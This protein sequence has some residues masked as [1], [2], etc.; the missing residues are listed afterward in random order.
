M[1]PDMPGALDGLVG[2]KYRQDVIGAR[3]DQLALK[4]MWL[5]NAKL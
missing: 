4:G 2:G 3:V 5:I 1:I